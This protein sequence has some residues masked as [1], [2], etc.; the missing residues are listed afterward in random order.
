M[1]ITCTSGKCLHAIH[2]SYFMFFLRIIAGRAGSLRE[3][4]REVYESKQRT[5]SSLVKDSRGEKQRER[6]ST[7]RQGIAADRHRSMDASGFG[8]QQPAPQGARRGTYSLHSA[9]PSG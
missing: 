9:S 1:N 8:P 7:R 4:E 5:S 3:R 2:A 6:G